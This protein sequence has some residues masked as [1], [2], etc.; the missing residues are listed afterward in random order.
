M[1]DPDERVAA[2]AE[3]A[4]DEFMVGDARVSV[5]AHLPVREAKRLPQLMARFAETRNGDDVV[6]L[7]TLVVDEWGFE[8][9][10]RDPKAYQQLDLFDE[11]LAIGEKVAVALNKR[12]E[13]GRDA[14]VVGDEPHELVVA[15]QRVSLRKRIPLSLAPRLPSMMGRFGETGDV[16]DLVKMLVLVV[17][18]WD[19]AG[20]P[21]HP[22]SY[23][24]MDVFDALPLGERA[25]QYLNNKLEFARTKN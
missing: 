11:V 17:E 21:E 8:G 5:R 13:R 23:Q 7:L 22:N 3:R 19:F 18:S 25:I 20:S 14:I 2:S 9:S 16:D 12:M 15:G 6:R 4:G 10:P 1:D 24:A